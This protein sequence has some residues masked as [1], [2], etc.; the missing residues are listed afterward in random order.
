MK[1][2]PA[3]ELHDVEPGGVLTDALEPQQLAHLGHAGFLGLADRGAAF[4]FQRRDLLLHEL[5]AGELAFEAGQQPGRSGRTVPEAQL[6]QVGQEV[7]VHIEV[8]AMAD[9]QSLDAIHVAR[10]FAFQ[11]Q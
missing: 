11:G 3:E 6:G 9:Q 10:A 8:D 7:A 4:G 5:P 2:A 1:V